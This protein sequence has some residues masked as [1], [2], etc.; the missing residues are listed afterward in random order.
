V[1]TAVVINRVRVAI[2]H[3]GTVAQPDGVTPRPVMGS[4]H[5]NVSAGVGAVLA[6]HCANHRS[7]TPSFSA[8]ETGWS[9]GTGS[10]GMF[11]Q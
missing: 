2:G 9:P 7:V 10:G 6:L 3:H 1:I 5:L 4:G 8:S 11:N